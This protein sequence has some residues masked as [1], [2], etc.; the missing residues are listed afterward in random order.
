MK[1]KSTEPI[2][3]STKA[4]G[5]L[6]AV[7]IDPGATTPLFQQI[8]EALRQDILKGALARGQRLV[9]TRVMAKDLRVSRNTVLEA[10][11]QLTAE[12]YLVSRVGSGTFVVEDLPEELLRVGSRSTMALPGKA[13][14]ISSRGR[15]FRAWA[16]VP[17]GARNRPFQ[18]GRPAID[19]FP[20]KTWS[21]L[22]ARRAREMPREW[23]DYAG[24]AGYRPLR[25]ALAR[26]LGSSRGLSCTPEQIVIVRG[27]QQGLDLA[28]RVLL[29]VGDPVW[30]E[31]PGY[32][33]ARVA[34]AAN[35]AREVPVPVDAEG[36]QVAVGRDREPRARLAY[37]TPSH[38]YPLG[39]TLSLSRRLE[40]LR[41]ARETDA[42]IVEDDYD[43][44]YRF[45]GRP[46][47]SLAGLDGGRHVIYLGTLSKVLFPALRL[48]FLVV[49]REHVDA[50]VGARYASD[51]HTSVLEQAV[52]ADFFEEG[53][54]ARHVCRMRIL[55]AARQK[56][57]SAAVAEH[58]SEEID[59]QLSATG[60]HDVGWLRRRDDV[61]VA[62]L[63]ATQGVTVAALSTYCEES[64]QPPGLLFGY[65]G[66]P[67]DELAAAVE[68]L[69]KVFAGASST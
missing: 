64:R 15:G 41:W 69:G 59:L 16:E 36:L 19:G 18:L 62:E 56:R 32:P 66:F 21:R 29:D 50:F 10:V 39:V 60:L 6:A 31:D 34:F 25:E 20:W 63:A 7:R 40:L 48:G 55:Y 38:Q 51:R 45:A 13:P 1:V 28:A 44:E 47:A 52:V 37:V 11:D 4:V 42:W 46:L 17:G 49:P 54:F 58:L 12:G 67:S 24:S 33:A 22:A 53:H 26:Y 9:A 14:G 68:R 5:G 30:I 27:S 2:L 57:L 43:S 8:Y 65:A 61:E 23:L 35:G 3:P